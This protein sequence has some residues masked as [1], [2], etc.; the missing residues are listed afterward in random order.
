VA[1]TVLG[2][3]DLVGRKQTL[4]HWGERDISQFLTGISIQLPTEVSVVKGKLQVPGE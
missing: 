4:A 3:R 1:S 2:V